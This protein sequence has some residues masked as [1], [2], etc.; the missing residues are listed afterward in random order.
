MGIFSMGMGLGFMLGQMISATLLSPLLG[1]W[2]GVMYFYG[3]VSIAFGI[4]WYLFGREPYHDAPPSGDSESIPLRQ[5]LSKLIHIK[6]LWLLGF[7]LLLRLG[8]IMGMSGYMPLYLREHG[9]TPASADVAMAF[10]YGAS[11][12][13]VVP[14]S[15]LSDKLG[16]RKAFQVT[17][18]IVTLFCF[19]LLPVV[20]GIST[21]VLM[22]LSGAFMDCFMAIMVT[23]VLETEGVGPEAYGTAIGF[24]LTI[25]QV[26]SIVSPPLGNSLASLN[27]GLPFIFWATLSGAALFTLTP[28]KDHSVNT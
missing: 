2:R 28:I 18:L 10:F 21:W 3:A 20:D 12:L 7:T 25:A 9:W 16:A 22:I 17:A 8:S 26:G 1:G 14:L 23:M 11:M 19:G 15:S 24:L 5:A 6:A 27:T 13:C 4:L